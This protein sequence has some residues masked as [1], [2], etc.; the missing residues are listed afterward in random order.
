[1]LASL[2][3]AGI[4]LRSFSHSYS[5]SHSDP[6]FLLFIARLLVEEPSK[7]H[8][9]HLSTLREKCAKN[10]MKLLKQY[11]DNN[12][13]VINALL[14]NEYYMKIQKV[15]VSS[16][17]TGAEG[18][19]RPSTTKQPTKTKEGEEMLESFHKFEEIDDNPSYSHEAST[20][21]DFAKS[22]TAKRFMVP[23]NH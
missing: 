21:K 8:A 13:L 14:S 7:H 20:D 9:L 23:D 10:P 2:P 1:M 17:A 11:S 18:T 4:D 5:I 12:D 16:T 15:G 19:K 3:L 22:K 6:S